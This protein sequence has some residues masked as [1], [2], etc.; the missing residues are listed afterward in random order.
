M[1]NIDRLD[2]LDFV[3]GNCNNILEISEDTGEGIALGCPNDDG[4]GEDHTGFYVEDI[5]METLKQKLDKI[6]LSRFPALAPRQAEILYL[7]KQGK[8]DLEISTI[9][10][11]S[12]RTVENILYRTKKKMEAMA[13]TLENAQN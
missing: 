10:C 3:C 11:R 2:D 6:I 8:T 9:L 1:T 13:V 4:D 5:D 12:I 7:H